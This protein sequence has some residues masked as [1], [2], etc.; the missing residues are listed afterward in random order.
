MQFI[1]DNISAT[2]VGSTI[3]LMLVATNHRNMLASTEAT[4][5]YMM[6]KQSLE[7]TYTLK[8]DLQ[9]VSKVVTITENSDSTF[10]FW[11][12]TDPADTSKHEVK[13]V[14]SKTGVR[15]STDLFQIERFVDNVYA[16]GSLSTMT[17]WN[18]EALNEQGNAIANV[19]DARQIYVGFKMALPIP[20]TGQ[21]GPAVDHLSWEATFQPKLIQDIVL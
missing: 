5:F 18:I 12:Q 7:F 6:S 3:L 2:I 19:N 4:S 8:H 15:D 17:E 10:T 21:I 20:S 13:Y 14:R 16:G 9:N 11:A 1:L